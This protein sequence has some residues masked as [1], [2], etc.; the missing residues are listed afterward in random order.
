MKNL[1][2]LAALA[3]A[4][5]TTSTAEAQR[6]RIG[7]TY[8]VRLAGADVDLQLSQRISLSLG[9]VVTSPH[10]RSPLQV[11]IRVGVD[12]YLAG[13]PHDGFYVRAETTTLVSVRDRGEQAA[14]RGDPSMLGAILMGSTWTMDN[15]YVAGVAV[16]G[17]TPLTSGRI[18]LSVTLRLSLGIRF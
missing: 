11:G 12:V 4:L 15:R 9:P 14:P 5:G 2:V 16:G 1:V 7:A 13:V 8:G 6:V 17:Q 10:L 3:G 18:R